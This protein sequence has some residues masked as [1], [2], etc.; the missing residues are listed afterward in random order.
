MGRS[1]SF[2][3]SHTLKPFEMS[4]SSGSLTH[5][6]LV[7]FGKMTRSA[8]CLWFWVAEAFAQ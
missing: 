1:V 8:F 5:V 4:S 7:T 2:N 3:V 6:R